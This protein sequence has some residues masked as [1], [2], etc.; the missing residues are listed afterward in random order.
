MDINK[1]VRADYTSR[2]YMDLAYEALEAWK[3][4]SV[5][6]RSNLGNDPFFHKSGWIALSNEGSDFADRI[7]RNFR[8]RGSDFTSDVAVDDKL[9]ERWDGVLKDVDV[10]EPKMV[11]G[12][13]NPDAG[14]ADAGDAVAKMMEPL[15]NPITTPPR[16]DEFMQAFHVVAP[17]VPGFGFSDP[18]PEAANNIQATAEI[19]DALMQGLGYG[20]YMMF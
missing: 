20:K 18:V 13:W 12:Y 11:K 19:F 6:R 10:K 17:S 14:W 4:W 2:F 3:T 8:D 16:G 5:L 1:I 9:R 7:R 15:C